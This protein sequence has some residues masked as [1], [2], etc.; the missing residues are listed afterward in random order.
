MKDTNYQNAFGN[1]PDS[2]KN[3][4]AS[5][6]AH[7]EAEPKMKRFTIRLVAIAAMLLVLLAGVVYAASTE[8]GLFDFFNS[9]YDRTPG[10]ELQKTLDKNNIRQSFEAGDYTVT[11]QEAIADGRYLYITA[12]VH[13][14]D[15]KNIYMMPAD[16]MPDDPI[17]I[18]AAKAGGKSEGE[19]DQRTFAQAAMEEKKRLVAVQLGYGIT[20]KSDKPY[21]H[22]NRNDDRMDFALISGSTIHFVLGGKLIPEESRICVDMTLSTQEWSKEQGFGKGAK[23]T[24]AFRF[25]LPVTAPLMEKT[26]KG[27][28]IKVPD[29][30]AAIDRVEL[31]LTPLTMHYEIYYTRDPEVPLPAAAMGINGLWFKFTDGAGNGIRDGLSLGGSRGSRDDIHFTQTGSIMM[32]KMPNAITLQGYERDTGELHGTVTLKVE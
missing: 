10:N 32:E 5:A 2:F 15:G 17:S 22:Y 28:G 31:I 30:D 23:V 6:L 1:A 9:M 8:W 29:T 14:K 3:R 11:I 12:A 19:N 27:D 7:R 24:E 20:F 26:I 25:D 4:V 18:W 16:I 13:V 21:N